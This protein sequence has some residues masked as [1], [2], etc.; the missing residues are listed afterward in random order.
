[1]RRKLA[2]VAAI[3]AL[4]FTVAAP[5]AGA[6]EVVGTT[7]TS[8]TITTSDIST[9]EQEILNGL[10]FGIGDF[11]AQTGNEITQFQGITEAEYQAQAA[12]VLDGFTEAHGSELKPVLAD[13]QSGNINRVETGLNDLAQLYSGYLEALIG[14]E[15]Y[16]AL[17]RSQDPAPTACGV[18]VVCVAYAAAA[19]HNTVAITGL[20]A[21]VVGGAVACG[22]WWV[23]CGLSAQQNTSRAETEYFVAEVT[24]AA[25]A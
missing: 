7:D 3:G 25:K 1:M 2:L 17:Q 21:V 22:V 15:D 20:A 13:L 5:P 24:R 10:L 8:S 4:T 19:V 14:P 16:A 18:A 6:Y 11:A 9:A 12:V 23:D